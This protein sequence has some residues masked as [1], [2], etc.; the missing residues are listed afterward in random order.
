MCAVCIGVMWVYSKNALMWSQ[1]VEG[2]ALVSE[3]SSFQR[4]KNHVYSLLA[5]YKED[6]LFGEVFLSSEVSFKD[7][8]QCD[9]FE[10]PCSII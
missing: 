5:K 9:W 7:G 10:K 1:M 8:F 2:S 4:L 3:V 6:V